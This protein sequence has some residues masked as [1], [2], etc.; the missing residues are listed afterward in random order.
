MKPSSLRDVESFLTWLVP[1]PSA[2]ERPRSLNSPFD[3]GEPG[4]LIRRAVD[5]VTTHLRGGTIGPG[6]PID[7]LHGPDGGKMFG[8]LVV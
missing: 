4:P 7:V 2:E 5:A 1:Q 8:V 3:V 6:L